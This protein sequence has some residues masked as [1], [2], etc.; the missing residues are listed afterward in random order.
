M[1]KSEVNKRTFRSRIGS[2][3]GSLGNIIFEILEPPAV[4]KYSMY[5]LGI[6]GTS[7]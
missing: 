2:R 6:S 4:Q 7:S 1:Q 5:M 3:I